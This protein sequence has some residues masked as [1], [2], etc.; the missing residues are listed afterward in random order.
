[1]TYGEIEAAAQAIERVNETHTGVMFSDL[2]RIMA[3]EALEAAAQVR[4]LIE[5]GRLV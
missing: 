2:V 4:E 1:M 3:R 5:R